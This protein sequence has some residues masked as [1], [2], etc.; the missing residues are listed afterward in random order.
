MDTEEI[1]KILSGNIEKEI[2]KY[3]DIKL[4]QEIRIK[5]NKPLILLGNNYE[6]ITNYICDL[7]DIN[8]IMRRITNYSVYAVQEEIKQGYITI[9]GGHRVGICGSCIIEDNVIKTIK[10]AA[11]INIRI[12]KEIKNCSDFI[13]RYIIGDNTVLNTIIISPPQCGKTTLLRDIARNISDGNKAISLKGQKVC[14]VDE[15]SEIGACYKGIPQLDLGIRTDIL[16]NCPKSQ[17][18]MMAIRSMSPQ[19]IICDEIGTHEDMK[20]IMSALTC[21]VS[22]VTTIHGFGIED[23]YDRAVF[24]DVMQNK[25]FHRAI[26]LS[27]KKGVGTVEYIYDFKTQK[28]I[29]GNK[30]D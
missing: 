4:L 10:E 21:G 8:T 7:E 1:M 23:L 15:R 30:Y 26:I 16:D 6:K 12:C 24:N 3:L 27:A 5:V 14:V 11:S 20:S 2:S 29:W 28:K 25:V 9:K 19:T 22:I 18:I 13:M 17:G